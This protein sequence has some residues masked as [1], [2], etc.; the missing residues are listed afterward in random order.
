M[1]TALI[2]AA[3]LAVPMAPGVLVAFW[4]MAD[5]LFNGGHDQ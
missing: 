4:I 1:T 5:E 3:L 2:I